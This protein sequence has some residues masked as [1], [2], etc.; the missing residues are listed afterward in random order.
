[1]DSN[2]ATGSR[3][4]RP[5]QRLGVLL[6]VLL[7]LGTGT[8]SVAADATLDQARQLIENNAAK[9]AYDL[10]IPQQSERA[11]DAEYD[12]LL[13]IAAN[14][15]GKY[16]E[17]VFAL[18]R[19]LAVQPGNTRARAEIARA[20]FFLGERPT[21]KAE[22]EAI[23]KQSVPS[24]VAATIQKYL[25]AIQRVESAERTTFAGYVEMSIGHDSNVN[26]ATSG[27]Q[28]ALP[29]FGGAVLTLGPGSTRVADNFGSAGAGISVRHMLT[30][31]LALLAGADLNKRVN[32]DQGTF[33]TGFNSENAGL[34]YT[35]GKQ[36][37]T[38]AYQR[39]NFYVGYNLFRRAEGVIGQFQHAFD[40]ANSLTAYAQWTPLEYPGQDI[41][42]ADRAGGG[43]AFARALGGDLQPVL[44]A[45]AYGGSEAEKSTGVPQLGNS[46]WGLRFGGQLNIR[47]N[48]V[49]FATATRE[50]RRYGGPDP[51][52]LTNRGDTQNDQA[53]GITYKPAKQW[54]IT[55]QISHTR[56]DSN[57]MINQ[58]ERTQFFVTVRREFK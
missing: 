54:S 11:G 2:R 25:D 29:V 6:C 47:E 3:W 52:F 40:E 15:V 14:S 16:S 44:F 35:H 23:Q 51:L 55:P 38:L 41:R 34:S 26:A 42:N 36:T 9:A 5:V 21:A 27:N 30:P 50:E 37:Y 4:R 39:Q 24:E 45:G 31:K 43:L 56:N 20:Y 48:L 33:N 53:I 13:G 12:L 32:S 8:A 49:A 1:M 22:F 17:A 46:F 28:V 58:F 7:L 57:I 19:V 18:E 10:L